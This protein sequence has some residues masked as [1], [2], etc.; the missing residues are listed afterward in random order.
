RSRTA[1]VMHYGGLLS[2][3]LGVM[4][5]VA[6]RSRGGWMAA[7]GG[8]L[9]ALIMLLVAMRVRGGREASATK[10]VLVPTLALG[11]ALV[12]ASFVPVVGREPLPSV[13]RSVE[14]LATGVE[15]TLSIRAA[16]QLNSLAL[17]GEQPLLGAGAGRFAA[18]YPPLHARWRETPGFG[19]EK[20]PEHVHNDLVEYAA[21]LGLP[22]ALALAVALIV[23]WFGAAR[24]LWKGTDLDE[25]VF[26]AAIGGGLAA[27]LLHSLVSFPLHSPASAVA[28]WVLAG[29]G[30]AMLGESPKDPSSIEHRPWVARAIASA[31]LGVVALWMISRDAPAQ[32]AV[33]RALDAMHAGDCQAAI[34]EAR[35]AAASALRR[36]DVTL[37][38]MIAFEC[39]KDPER[40]LEL[41]EPALAI[42]PHHLNVL[43]AAG[44]RR[45]KADRVDD[46]ESAFRHALEIKPDLGRGWLGLAMTR[47][48]RGDRTGAT[49]ACRQALSA[50]DPLPAARTFCVGNGY[51]SA[52]EASSS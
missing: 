29:R 35:R 17:I 48:A 34:A 32:R 28:A 13:G 7:A 1:R 2:G 52:V 41:I 44:A 46:A 43:L 25:V 42:N 45:L 39:E 37:S 38:A 51:V 16:L 33:G 4:L 5:L 24:R 49:Q 11:A 26:A 12:V 8:W 3:V 9:I 40:S 22:A 23:G 20:R 27:A 14:L 50:S 36:R 47:D 30:W 21:E 15:Q 6:T 31:L 18:A 10:R 19:L